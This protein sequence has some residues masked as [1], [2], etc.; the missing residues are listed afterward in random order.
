MRGKRL[1]VVAAAMLCVGLITV[2]WAQ[3]P[4]TPRQ[5]LRQGDRPQLTAE[6]REQVKSTIAEMKEEGASREEIGAA[7]GEMLKEWGIEAPPP[8]RMQQNA[9][10]GLRWL[11]QQLTAEQREELKAEVQ[12]MREQGKSP[13]EIHAAVKELLK[14]WGIEP[15]GPGAGGQGPQVGL[16]WLGQQLTAE[17]REELK[18]EVQQMREQGASREEIGAA[19]K[20]MLK[21]WGIE[22]PTPQA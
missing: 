3:D 14:G 15:P 2:V 10:A 17:Q 8:G 6:Q 9:Q 19:V 16:R 1:W 22:R 12:E 7:V 20:E 13:E 4:T 5:H 18:A 21:D 11:G